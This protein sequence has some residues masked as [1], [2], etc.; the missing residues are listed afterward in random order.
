V[1][2]T[3]KELHGV[4]GWLWWFV[5]IILGGGVLMSLVQTINFIAG[6]DALDA[7]LHLVKGALA[8]WALLLMQKENPKGLTWAKAYLIVLFA[9]SA[10][11]V[12]LGG[13]PSGSIRNIGVSIAWLGYLFW[14][15]RVKNTYYPMDETQATAAG[16]AVKS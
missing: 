12:V 6:K 4:H 16:L 8:L 1:S 3:I 5:Y 14:S 2:T 10:L 9:E 7:V 13:T 15:V 11:T